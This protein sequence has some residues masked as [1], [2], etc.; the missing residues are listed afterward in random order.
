MI[1][2]STFNIMVVALLLLVI[3]SWVDHRN[4]L[5]GNIAAAIL[6][7]LIGGVLAI[8]MYIG[9]VSTDAGTPINDMPTAGILFLI[10]LTIAVYSFFMIMEAK[11]E[12]EA[13]L[14]N[15]P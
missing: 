2:I 6:A 13:E 12:Y 7:S 14:E 8:V 15:A 9:A 5:Y 4:K 3:Y 11:E 10:T 1:P